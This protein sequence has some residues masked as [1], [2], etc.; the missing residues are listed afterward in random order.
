MQR[1]GLIP[2]VEGFDYLAFAQYLF[3]HEI[4][5]LQRICAN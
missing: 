3:A 4:R 2:P 5:E 1:A